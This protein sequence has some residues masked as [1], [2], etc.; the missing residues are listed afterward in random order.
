M[1]YHNHGSRYRAMFEPKACDQF[2]QALLGRGGGAKPPVDAVALA[3]NLGLLVAVDCGQTE[4]GRRAC[5]NVGGAEP[6]PT[7]FVGNEERNERRQ[8]AVAHEIG[9]HF[10]EELFRKLGLD[11]REM[12]RQTR[13]QAANLIA[14]RL[15][16]P[17]ELFV[18]A[19]RECDWDL[20]ELKR[21]FTTASHELIAR[22]II[23]CLA[24]AI[25]TIFD[26]GRV[27][28]RSDGFGRRSPLE[29]GE[30]TALERCRRTLKPA[31]ATTLHSRV[32]CW[33]IYEAEWRRGILLTQ[34]TGGDDC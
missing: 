20:I 19:G 3:A 21:R 18:A 8:W 31:A 9:E 2:A 13:E 14:P 15:L 33:P 29:I 4:R 7:I 11:P 23:D 22:R 17:R 32:R 27:R 30:R 34:S 28:F 24:S 25:V 26:Q 16:L 12:P 5:V 10:S 6:L 1:F